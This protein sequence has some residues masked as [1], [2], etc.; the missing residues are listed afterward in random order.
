MEGRALCS[1]GLFLG[2][3]G[4]SVAT[5]GEGHD[6]AGEQEQARRPVRVGG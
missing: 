2:G 1:N 4:K 5:G 6:M 3:D